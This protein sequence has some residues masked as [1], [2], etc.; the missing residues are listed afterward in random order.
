[1]AFTLP[2]SL[3]RDL[4]PVD[5]EVAWARSLS[6]EERLRVVAALCRDNL[7]LLNMNPHRARVLAMRDPVPASTSAAL[8][9]LR[10]SR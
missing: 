6:P 9:R 8:Q 5:D 7:I 3:R 1:M 2:A 10:L 4:H